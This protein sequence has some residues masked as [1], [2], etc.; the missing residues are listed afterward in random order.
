[1]HIAILRFFGIQFLP[2]EVLDFLFQEHFGLHFITFFDLCLHIL[3]INLWF[4]FSLY[5]CLCKENTF[6]GLAFCVNRV[7]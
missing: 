1:M 7:F 6:A 5:V 2:A 3:C 4:F